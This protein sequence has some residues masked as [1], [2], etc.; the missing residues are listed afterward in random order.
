MQVRQSVVKFLAVDVVDYLS[1]LSAGDFPVLPLSA[2]AFASI[3]KTQRLNSLVKMPVGFFDRRSRDF[4]NVIFR[5]RGD[6]LIS[7]PV[8]LSM[9]K[10]ADLLVVRV[11]RVAMVAKHLVVPHAKV[12]GDCRSVAVFARQANRLTAPSVVEG[13]VLLQPLVVH[14]AETSSGVLPPAALN[15]ANP[16]FKRCHYPSL[17]FSNCY[18]GNNN[19][20][21]KG[22][23]KIIGNSW[24]VPKFEWLGRRIAALM[25]ATISPSLKE[26]A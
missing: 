19:R 13:A 16:V 12:L 20:E 8:V 5:N 3:P 9:R 4:G 11:K 6:H 2:G 1:R 21:G 14:E 25:P 7:S 18:I 24:A 22:C 26:A 15:V 23:I 17:L 10:A